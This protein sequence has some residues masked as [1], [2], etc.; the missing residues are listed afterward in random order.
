[1]GAW[2]LNTVAKE[3]ISAEKVISL[4]LIDNDDVILKAVKSE[5]EARVILKEIRGF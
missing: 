1:M 3:V 4:P 2:I 5:K